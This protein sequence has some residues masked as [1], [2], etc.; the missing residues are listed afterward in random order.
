[1]NCPSCGEEVTEDHTLVPIWSHEG[2]LLDC[3]HVKTHIHEVFIKRC[4]ELGHDPNDVF[5]W[6]ARALAVRE[7]E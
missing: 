7:E 1:M 2:K 6:F 3:I 5:E 4:E